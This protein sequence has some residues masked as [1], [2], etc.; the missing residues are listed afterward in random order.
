MKTQLMATAVALCGMVSFAGAEDSQNLL[1]TSN[2]I[3][4][5]SIYNASDEAVASIDTVVL[6]KKGEPQ[7]VVADVGGVAGIG[8]THAAIPWKALDCECTMEDGERQCRATISMTQERLA[9]APQLKTE[10]YTELSDEEWLKTNA[11]FYST[12]APQA[13]KKPQDLICVATVTDAD[14]QG[15]NQESVGHLDA[16]IF[17]MK[18]G[19]AA[20]G[21]IGDGGTVGL[22]EKY[23]AVP[24]KA[25]N[26]QSKNEEM[27]V[28]INATPQEI[29]EAPVVTP[30]NY[31]ELELASVRDR[32]NE[33]FNSAK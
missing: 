26:F 21:V 27:H 4:G 7:F 9:K 19:K 33:S 31:P 14:I 15:S 16:I 3:I 10:K 11:E 18:S 25:L 12:E 22:N 17:D 20:Y 13:V 28:S 23:T 2:K 29:E 5:A 6:N 32:L 30:S 24:F 8:G 1:V